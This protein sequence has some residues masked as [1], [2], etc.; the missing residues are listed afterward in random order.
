M[1]MFKDLCF[2]GSCDF[3]YN[4]QFSQKCADFID[5][6]GHFVFSEFF[7]SSNFYYMFFFNCWNLNIS[8]IYKSIILI[9]SVNLPVIFIYKFCRQEILIQPCALFDILFL[10]VQGS[11]IQTIYRWKRSDIKFL[12]ASKFQNISIGNFKTSWSSCS[13]PKHFFLGW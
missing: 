7:C 5:P 1:K 6:S 3:N 12:L 11:I 9:F 2:F 10:C 4:L 8:A 13:F